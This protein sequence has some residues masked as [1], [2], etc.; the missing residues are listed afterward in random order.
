MDV[1][2]TPEQRE[3]QRAVR[4]VATDVVAPCAGREGFPL[5]V[6]RR[7]GEL[8]LFGIPFPA[9]YGG[10][11]GGLL[12]FCV[13]LEELGRADASVASMLA[14]AVCL[15]ANAVFRLGSEEQRSR[16]LVPMA[17][18][19]SIAAF[20]LLEEG[21]VPPTARSD[22]D[23][24]TLD[25]AVLVANAATPR[26]RLCVVA[27]RDVTAGGISTFAVPADAAGLSVRV[28]AGAPGWTAGAHAATLSGCRVPADHLL[29]EPGLGDAHLLEILR[30]GWVADAAVTTG[31][32]LG[33]EG[34]SGTADALRSAYRRAAGLRDRG[35]PNGAEATAAR[36]L[37]SGFRAQAATRTGRGGC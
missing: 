6:V 20:A 31:I 22:G 3:F 29:G 36:L 5:E 2:L 8:G 13:C 16:W 26:T 1:E 14:S 12:T 34:E 37:A 35:G 33:R 4:D 23:G 25:G 15:G 18:G 30:D 10:L 9:T 17:R 11:D 28:P 19:R 24:W 32:A 27:A 21:I 7:L